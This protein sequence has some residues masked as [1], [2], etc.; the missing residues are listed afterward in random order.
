MKL[1]RFEH[2]AG[3]LL[4]QSPHR[5]LANELRSRDSRIELICTIEQEKE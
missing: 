1:F 5:S 2:R 3:I 4:R